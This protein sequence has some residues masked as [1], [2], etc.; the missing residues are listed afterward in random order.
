MQAE[1]FYNLKEIKEH[2]NISKEK[3]RCRGF[4]GKDT[5]AVQF[6]HKICHQVSWG[7]FCDICCLHENGPETP[8][9][10]IEAILIHHLAAEYRLDF[11]RDSN[12]TLTHSGAFRV[13][14]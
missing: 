12:F 4:Y 8:G 2:R 10:G 3:V 11:S 1:W 7:S 13:E 6:M 5:C 9:N 14:R